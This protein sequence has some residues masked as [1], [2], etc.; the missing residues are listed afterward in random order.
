MQ[1]ES[2]RI[3]LCISMPFMG[4]E[5]IPY[6]DIFKAHIRSLWKDKYYS[7]LIESNTD[8][9]GLRAVVGSYG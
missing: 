3:K 6:N 4:T 1:Y 2:K 7:E 9:L 8:I 5:I